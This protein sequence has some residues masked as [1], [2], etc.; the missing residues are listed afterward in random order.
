TR[1][2]SRFNGTAFMYDTGKIVIAG[3]TD[4]FSVDPATASAEMID[5][6]APSPTWNYIAP[7]KF[8]RQYL[9]STILPDGKVL[10]S[11]GT[12]D[13]ANTATGA[14]LPAEIWDP[15]TGQWTV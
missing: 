9:N 15:A 3:G 1:Y 4:N 10:I 13:P 6:T 12:S 2:G 5:L 8:A 7:M 14:I 11:G